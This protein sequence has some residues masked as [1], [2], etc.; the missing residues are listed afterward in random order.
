ME[1]RISVTGLLYIITGVL[2]LYGI[3]R[4]MNMMTIIFLIT[5]LISI[6]GLISAFEKK[7]KGGSGGVSQ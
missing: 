3:M 7:D 6:A 5:A 1:I 4:V 2:S